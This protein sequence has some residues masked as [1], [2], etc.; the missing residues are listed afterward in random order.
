MLE[1]L[2]D[3]A[4]AENLDLYQAVARVDEARAVR[5]RVA[6]GRA[7]VVEAGA[8]V[9]RRRQ[10]ANG[11]LPIAAIPGMDTT[12][13]IHDVGFDAAWELDLFGGNRR[14]PEGANARLHAAGLEAEG[15]RMRIVADVRRTWFT[16]VGS[17]QGVRTEPAAVGAARHSPG[18]AGGSGEGKRGG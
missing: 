3:E 6:G 9:N 16:A 15:V 13:T 11:S 12:Q 5:D 10:S 8:S 14:A 18:G 1:A 2:V 4:L 17:G 7:P